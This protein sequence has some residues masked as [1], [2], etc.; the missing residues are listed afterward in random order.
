MFLAKV[1]GSLTRE[2]LVK[3]IFFY[4]LRLLVISI[5]ALE[6][7]FHEDWFEK[8]P[9]YKTKIVKI[10]KMHPK[11]P[12]LLNKGPFFLT[13]ETSS[14]IPTSNR[15]FWPEPIYWDINFVLRCL[16]AQCVCVGMSGKSLMQN[17]NVKFFRE[18][19]YKLGNRI[20]R[21][22]QTSFIFW[23]WIFLERNYSSRG[24]MLET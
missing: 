8:R 1:A 21:A 19:P 17:F 13:F 7:K 9:R 24:F 22:F 14:W 16:P 3:M 15:F 4:K 11:K 5:L 23:V 12:F 2:R 6:P 18:N 20:P 10:L